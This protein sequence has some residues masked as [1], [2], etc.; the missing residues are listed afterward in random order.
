[1]L[2]ESV[3]ANPRSRGTREALAQLSPGDQIEQICG[4]EA[5]AQDGAWS[6]DLQP[7]RI[8]A[9]ATADTELSGNA[10]LAEGA[11]LHSSKAWYRLRFRCELTPDHG[12]VAS[13]EFQMGDPIPREDWAQHHLPD[14]TGTAD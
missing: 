11:A 13:F 1:M 8:V 5:M 2:S 6:K 9:Y 7:D 14:E 10:F 4:L 12:K 3:L